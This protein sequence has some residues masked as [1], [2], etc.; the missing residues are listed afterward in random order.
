MKSG[1]HPDYHTITVEMTDGTKFQTRSTWG[2]EGDTLHLDIDPTVAPGVD[3]RQPAA[4]RHRRPGCALQQALRRTFPRQEV[5]DA[6]SLSGR[7]VSTALLVRE[8]PRIETER[9]SCATWREGRFPTVSR[10]HAA[11]RGASSLRAEAMSAR[12]M[13]APDAGR[14]RAAGSSSASAPGRSS[15][16]ATAG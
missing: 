15:A 3:R 14:C 4:A 6:R 11:A 16:R 5:S 13:L 9:L 1:T 8:A 12:G 10:N 2:K 7:Q